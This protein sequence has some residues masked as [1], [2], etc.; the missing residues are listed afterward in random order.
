METQE[1]NGVTYQRREGLTSILVMG[2]DHDSAVE[3]EGA[4]QGGQGDFQ[5]LIVIDPE[6]QVIRQLKIDRDTM[7]E[8]TVLGYLGSPIGTKEMQI[9]L[10]HGFGD[11]KEESCEYAREAVEGLLL[12]ESIDF[13]VAMNM[14]GIS[15][16]NDLAGGVT[17]TLEDDFSSIDPAMTKGTTLTLWGD[18]AEVYVRTRRSIG[19]GTNEA[20]MARQEQYIR[21]ITSQLDA[22]VQQ[23]QNFVLTAYD[24]LEPYLYTN[25]PRGQL[26]NEAWAAKD[27]E[28][29]DTIKPDGT[30][31]VGEDGFMEFYPDA[32]ALQQAVLQLFYEKVE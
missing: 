25:I 3:S 31:Q 1:Y 5:R 27:Y 30:Y 20:R 18:Q 16:L 8:C 22:K 26:A 7:T 9:S 13:Y 24:A 2:V 17:V 21:Q 19:V 23:D 29:M 6:R 32:D 10:A 28:R 11:G 12:G 15:E 14:D 4:Y